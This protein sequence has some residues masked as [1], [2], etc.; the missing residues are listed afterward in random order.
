ML[1]SWNLVK[2]VNSTLK[3]LSA[4]PVTAAFQRAA[5]HAS[6]PSRIMRNGDKA[7]ID[8]MVSH[9][10]LDNKKNGVKIFRLAGGLT[11]SMRLDDCLDSSEMVFEGLK[12]ECKGHWKLT[13]YG[14]HLEASRVTVVYPKENDNQLII[15]WLSRN[16]NGIGP[17]RCKI[18][19]DHYEGTDKSLI[20]ALVNKPEEVAS[21]I[22]KHSKQKIANITNQI[23]SVTGIIE[24]YNVLSLLEELGLDYPVA[25]RIRTIPDVVDK[26]K[27]NPYELLQ[28]KGLNFEI[29]D[30]Y[31]IRSGKSL[32]SQDRIIA[33][34]QEMIIFHGTKHGHI[35][36]P[37]DSLLNSGLKM[38]EL[39]ADTLDRLFREVLLLEDSRLVLV[40]IDDHEFVYPRSFYE[41]EREVGKR[42]VELSQGMSCFRRKVS[43]EVSLDHVIDT[44]IAEAEESNHR[45]FSDSQKLA[46]QTLFKSKVAIIT[47]G[48]GV[49]KTY[50]VKALTERCQMLD[51]NVKLC[52][53][54]GRAARRLTNMTGI[55]ATT[56]HRMLGIF[57][58]PRA[59][60]DAP[61]V[62]I[63]PYDALWDQNQ[64]DALLPMDV[65]KNGVFADII[66][67]DEA[68]MVD[69][70]LLN[71]L[72]KALP[73]HCSLVFVGDADQ[74][75]SIGPGMVLGDLIQSGKFDVVELTEIHRQGAGSNI[76]KMAQMVNNGVAP[77]S[78]HIGPNVG[79]FGGDT[80]SQWMKV[81]T[82]EDDFQ[83]ITTSS[84]ED[85]INVIDSIV[86]Y[87]SQVSQSVQ[88][89][90]AHKFSNLGVLELNLRYQKI[91]N[92]QANLN[93][94]GIAAN[95]YSLFLGDRVM[96]TINSY[97][98]N[99][100]NG[101][102]GVVV[103]ADYEKGSVG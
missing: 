30:K 62:D 4:R 7:F 34:L 84:N 102:V 42:I 9:V 28:V 44:W 41:A 58:A 72:I 24:D 86:R 45:E 83:F 88:M 95:S 54:T 21:L 55:T 53:P 10:L 1:S 76:V 87:H 93:A 11:V 13:D 77:P 22:Y 97:T 65:G 61:E 47:G 67:V 29:L 94:K 49:G 3:L 66:V 96:Q 56:I 14:L 36:L 85:T 75:P 48:P 100:F 101:E 57:S 52:A 74:L 98:K 20:G 37:F 18:L 51:I 103:A 33:F 5:F 91:L 73:P 50:L 6:S 99:V 80:N 63:D 15:K 90:C 32:E 69:V 19:F 59:N 92:R 2:G 43:R 16:V 46:L 12:V 79:V 27:H 89:L 64:L 82:D 25:W 26:I 81:V 38:L 40:K 60:A 17:K 8:G 71:Y 35:A 78:N 39:P 70:K 68:S 23:H 31:A